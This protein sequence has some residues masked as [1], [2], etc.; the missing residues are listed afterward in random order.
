MDPEAGDLALPEETVERLCGR[1][2]CP[3]RLPPNE[4]WS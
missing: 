3:E 1:C 4:V 2:L